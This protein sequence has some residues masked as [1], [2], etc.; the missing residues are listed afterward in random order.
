MARGLLGAMFEEASGHRFCVFV[1]RPPD[2]VMLRPNVDVVQVNISRPVT[3]AAVASGSR[4]VG[5]LWRFTR[6]ASREPM[7]LMFYPAVYSWFPIRPGVPVVVTLHDAIAERFPELVFPG[8]KARALWGLKMRLARWQA[9]RL[10]TVS[11]AAKREIVEQL[12]IAPGR[13]DVVSEAADANFRPITD[14]GALQAARRRAKLPAGGRYLV[15]ASGLAPHKNVDGL[16]KGFSRALAG[17]GLEDLHLAL[18]G[19]PEGGGFHSNYL[20]LLEQARS[21]PALRGRVHFTGY[22]SDEDLVALY[23]GAVAAA[24]PSLSE[25]FGLPAVE[26]MSCGTPVLASTAGAVPEVV[27]DAGLYFDPLETAQIADAI[28][29]IAT[30]PGTLQSLRERASR[31]AKRFTWASAARL[32][33]G[34]LERTAREA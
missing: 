27:G 8:R 15:Y 9:T 6:A 19:D 13:I 28:A 20:Q 26:S 22:V 31:R 23:S 14:P 24:V 5:D 32:A 30:E 1:D 12:G 16:V 29:R 21:D 33:L 4:S 34:H 2:P 7:D 25:G 11:E 17:P 3:E 18:V 10:M